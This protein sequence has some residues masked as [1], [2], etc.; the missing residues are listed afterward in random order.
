MTLINAADIDKALTVGEVAERSGVAVSTLHF[1]EK[2]GLIKSWR[3]AGN[4]R[5]YHRDVLRRVAVIKVA[6]RIGIPLAE[7]TDALSALPD[8]R[9]PTARDWKCLSARWREQLD[10]RIEQLTMLRNQLSDCIGCGCL[11]IKACRL[12]NPYDTLSEE[13]PGPHF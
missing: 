12:R 3:T 1:Y 5:R 9:S 13:G 2:K 6:Q 11:S 4:Q 8:G 7:I 10:E